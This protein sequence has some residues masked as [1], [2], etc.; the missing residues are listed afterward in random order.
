M[1]MYICTQACLSERSQALQG[2]DDL[3]STVRACLC[4]WK[5]STPWALPWEV[6]NR[7]PTVPLW[8]Y[9]PTGTVII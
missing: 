3:P 9:P 2:A 8:K 1:L 6:P 5:V 7:I 4:Q